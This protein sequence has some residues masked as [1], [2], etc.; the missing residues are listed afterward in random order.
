MCHF[1]HKFKVVAVVVN[2][3][4]ANLEVAN[5]E[6]EARADSVADASKPTSSLHTLHEHPIFVCNLTFVQ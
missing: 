3:E 2:L 1:K 6:A 4:V 5:L